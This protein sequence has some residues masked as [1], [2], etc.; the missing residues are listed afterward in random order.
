TDNAVS[1]TRGSVIRLDV[2]HASTF[3]G[4]DASQQ[5]NRGV[6]DATVYQALGRLGVLTVHARAG[7]VLAATGTT[8]GLASFVP[9]QERLYAGGP[10]TVRGFRQNELGPAVYIV[11]GLDTVRVGADLFLQ[12][13]TTATT[14]RVVPTGGNRLVVLNAELQV[15]SPVLP[16]L[17]QWAIFTDAG[18]VW[19]RTGAS[20]TRLAGG[21]LRFTP[22]AGVRILSPFGAIRFDLGYN[23]YELTDGAAYFNAPPDATTGRAPLYCVSP[24][25][26]LALR[27][28][29]D[30]TRIQQP[31]P[32]P[33]TFRPAARRGVLGRLNPSIWI[34]QAF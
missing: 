23:G 9:P 30:G 19:N 24:G 4:S 15:R 18:Q 16:R 32:C 28:D 25:N 7:A 14:E 10:T 12:V 17:L 27:T 31:G 3:I 2:R 33:A 6:F 1:P 29:T 26:R 34:G 22:G 20:T 13:D 8:R 5:F 11:R 21:G